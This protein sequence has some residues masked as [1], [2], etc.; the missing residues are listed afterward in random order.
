MAES[1]VLKI[2]YV[3]EMLRRTDEQHPIN[4]TQ[5]IEN[6]EQEGLSAERKSIGN[7]IRI[8]RE[9]MGYDILLSENRNLGW[10]M[11]DQTFED[12][13]LKLLVDAVN[14]AQFI[15]ADDTRKLRG[16]ILSLSTKEGERIIRSGMVMEESLKLVD[17]KFADKFDT[18][19]RAIAD[20]KQVS[21][22]YETIGSGGKKRP[23]SEGLVF[24][25][26]PYYLGVWG[27]EYYLVG[28]AAGSDDASFYRV[29][30]LKQVE[31]EDVTARPMSQVNQLKEVGR[32]GKTFGDFIKETINL[33]S[34]TVRSIRISGQN[35]LRREVMKKFG[36]D[37]MMRDNSDDRFVAY[38][39]VA[40]SRGFYQW[41]A[42]F[43]DQMKIEGP[44][45]CVEHF[46]DFL[47]ESLAQY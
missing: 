18:L 17:A 34:G 44:E 46:V 45:E 37:V 10:Y 26:S 7:Y 36:R 19:M 8:L 43:G 15:T 33:Q 22:Q 28:N 47:R 27:H 35:E 9:E 12:H 21:F 6:L 2:L 29:E 4:S 24:H 39:H 20:H 30:M 41:V 5:I 42:Q 11:I 32:E 31:I 40:D 25:V 16:K 38:L 13:E 23:V 14:A 3:L 1:N